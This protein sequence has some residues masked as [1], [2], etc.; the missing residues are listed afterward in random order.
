MGFMP[1][2]ILVDVET[3]QLWTGR[4]A[5]T[6]RRWVHEGRITRYG[7]PRDMRLDLRELP[8]HTAAGDPPPRRHAPEPRSV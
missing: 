1:E 7:G 3:A 4:P 8:H 5:G 6:L 2:P